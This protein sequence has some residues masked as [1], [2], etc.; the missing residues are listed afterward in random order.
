MRCPPHWARHARTMFLPSVQVWGN[1]VEFMQLKDRLRAKKALNMFFSRC[2]SG[3]RNQILRIILKPPRQHDR[4]EKGFELSP[5]LKQGG[6]AVT[7]KPG[8]PPTGASP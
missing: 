2:V 6:F 8:V 4:R 3:D 7:I 1:Y 5:V